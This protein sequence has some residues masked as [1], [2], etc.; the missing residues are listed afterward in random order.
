MLAFFVVGSLVQYLVIV[1]AVKRHFDD[2]DTIVSLVNGQP[3]CGV[4]AVYLASEKRWF[5]AAFWPM[6]YLLR[7]VNKVMGIFPSIIMLG[8]S[9][10]E[11][12]LLPGARVVNDRNH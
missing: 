5:F 4:N 6:Y 3:Y 12:K 8:Y 1:G 10:T 7:L 2:E 9:R 11:P